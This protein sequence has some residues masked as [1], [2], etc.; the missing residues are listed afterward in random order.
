L[1][2]LITGLIC[3]T[4]AVLAVA[5]IAAYCV[6]HPNDPNLIY[7]WG[8]VALAAAMLFLGHGTTTGRLTPVP[9]R[10]A[11]G[12]P[13]VPPLKGSAPGPKRHRH[14]P[15]GAASPSPGSYAA[16]AARK[17]I[18]SITCVCGSLKSS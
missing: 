10:N 7:A 15:D 8:M 4:S 17:A 18:Q 2:Y 9:A 16:T 12:W 5:A 14:P 11:P 1:R 3:W 6:A 13:L